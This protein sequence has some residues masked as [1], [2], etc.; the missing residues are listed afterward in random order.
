MQLVAVHVHVHLHVRTC[1]RT[2][3]R[4]RTDERIHADLDN[5]VS[6]LLHYLDALKYFSLRQWTLRWNQRLVY[7]QRMLGQRLVYLQRLLGLRQRSTAQLLGVYL[8]QE[9]TATFDPCRR[10]S[11]GARSGPLHV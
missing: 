11:R 2:Y 10:T 5:R 7:L 4:T 1:V 9:F 8:R 3:V 6:G